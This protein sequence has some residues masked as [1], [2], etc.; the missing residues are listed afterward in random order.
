MFGQGW[1]WLVCDQTGALAV[2]PTF[3]TGT[4]LIRS[5]QLLPLKVP[6][7]HEAIIGEEPMGRIPTARV[8]P[9][10]DAP[11]SPTSGLSRSSPPLQPPAQTRS[12]SSSS[13]VSETPMRRRD[14]TSAFAQEKL[15]IGDILFPLLSVSVHEH[16][17][18]GAGY[19][20]W[21]KEEYLKRFWNA[22]NWAQVS[23]YHAAY[24]PKVRLSS[25]A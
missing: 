9:S 7:V 10:Q 16:A 21:G 25:P 20:V 1:V 24:A 17:W 4:L 2:L 15:P 8:E 14:D 18:I 6:G 19:G 5:R 3:G 22:V 12:F 13:N 11:S 23:K